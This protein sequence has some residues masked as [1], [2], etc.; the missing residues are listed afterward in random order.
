[1]QIRRGELLARR[2][3]FISGTSG[4]LHRGGCDRDSGRLQGSAPPQ[5]RIRADDPGTNGRRLHPRP[6]E[7]TSMQRRTAP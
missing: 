5:A 4:S 3:T 7:G 2:S 1:L 6:G